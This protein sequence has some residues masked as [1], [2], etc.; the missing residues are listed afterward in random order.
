VQLKQDNWRIILGTDSHIGPYISRFNCEPGHVQPEE[1]ELLI[2]S[3]CS[4]ST[5][6]YTL[7]YQFGKIRSAARDDS[8]NY[9]GITSV[10]RARNSDAQISAFY[11]PDKALDIG[12]AILGSSLICEILIKESRSCLIKLARPLQVTFC[13]S[14]G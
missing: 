1:S 3:H 5:T 14:T 8:I 13:A 11:R 9:P 10:S 4:I 7:L 2:E 12:I 6:W